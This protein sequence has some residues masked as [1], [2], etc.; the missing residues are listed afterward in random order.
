MTMVPRLPTTMD[1]TTCNDRRQ[2]RGR[3]ERRRRRRRDGGRQD[4]GRGAWIRD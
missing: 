3:E 4:R 1:G 2:V